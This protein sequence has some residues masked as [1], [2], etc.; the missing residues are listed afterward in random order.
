MATKASR[1]RGQQQPARPKLSRATSCQT[2]ELTETVSRP[3]TVCSAGKSIV[4]RTAFVFVSTRCHSS[5]QS[6]PAAAS[7]AQQGFELTDRNGEDVDP[8]E[9]AEP[10]DRRQQ[11]VV[12]DHQRSQRGEIV[13]ASN[14]LDHQ[15][16]VLRS[17]WGQH[18]ASRS[19]D[20]VPMRMLRW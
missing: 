19:K 17:P 11:R 10:V 4:G 3:L 20:K 12:L 7:A 13:E 16:L 15:I 2:E 8:L 1:K 18:D 6:E 14:A 9:L 5:T